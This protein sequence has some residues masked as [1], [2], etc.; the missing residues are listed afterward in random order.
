MYPVTTWRRWFAAIAVGLA[1]VIAWVVVYSA[2]WLVVPGW[3]A[4]AALVGALGYR[5][6]RS[7]RPPNPF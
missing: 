4:A 1:L 5:V 3:I 2:S 7:P 6:R